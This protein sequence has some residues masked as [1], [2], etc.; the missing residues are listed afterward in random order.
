MTIGTKTLHA[1]AAETLPAAHVRH[2]IRDLFLRVTRHSA[3]LLDKFADWDAVEIAPDAS[4]VLWYTVRNA[5]DPS[6][7]RCYK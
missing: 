5:Y 7:K 6:V 4:G 3:K 1:I 2:D